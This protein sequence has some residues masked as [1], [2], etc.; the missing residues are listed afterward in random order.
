MIFKQL[1]LNNFKSHSN[2]TIDFDSGVT[3]IVG[4]NGAGKS[5]IFEAISF[6]L[7]KQFTS[8]NLADLMRSN[9]GEFIKE[10]SVSLVFSSNGIDYKIVRKLFKSKSKDNSESKPTVKSSVSLFK[11]DNQSFD[12]ISL[13]EGD[14]NV[15]NQIQ[16]ILEM[17]SDVFLNAIYVRQGEIAD[18]VGKT[19]AERKKLISKLLKLE[20]LEIAWKNSLDIINNY[21]IKSSELKGMIASESTLMVD[22]KAKKQEFISLAERK[23]KL[24]ND[25]EALNK[26]K[27]IISENKN[28]IEKEKMAF[29]EFTYK[30]DNEKQLFETIKKARSELQNQIDELSKNEEEMNRLEKYSKKLP[31]YIDFEEACKNLLILKK[32][33]E[34]QNA[35]L[36]KIKHH[37]EVLEN[38]KSAYDDYLI[39]ESKLKDL[40]EKKSKLSANLKIADKYNEDKKKVETSLKQEELKFKEFITKTKDVLTGFAD[41]LDIKEEIYLEDLED[42]FDFD[43]LNN[44]IKAIKEIID[45]D[46]KSNNNLTKEVLKEISTAQTNIESAKK[47]LEDLDE[48][49]GKCPICLSDINEDK[50]NELIYSYKNII[51]SKDSK[52][53]LFNGELS[54]IEENNKELSSKLELINDLEKEL[55]SIKSISENRNTHKKELL[56][57]TNKLKDLESALIELKEIEDSLNNVTKNI[58]ELKLSY[59][60]YNESK[61]A[62]NVLPKNQE[63]QEKLYHIEGRIKSE[64][65]RVDN[66]TKNDI[67][68]SVEMSEE[69]LE[70]KIK[71]LREKDQR[72]NQLTG[73]VRTKPKYISQLEEKKE[74]IK[75]KTLEIERLNKAIK[76]SKYDSEK[77]EKTKLLEEST[78]LRILNANKELSEVSGRIS[79][80]IPVIEKIENDLK[81]NKI[82]KEELESCE[83]F[84]KLLTDIRSLYSKDGIQKVLRN[85]SKPIIQKNTKE[86]FEKFNFE[87]SDLL[88]DENYDISLFGPEGEAKL[89]M[90]SGG[91]KIAVA[92]ALR[93]GI[94]KAMAKGNIE[95]ILLDEPTIHL[96]DGRKND[97]IG[98]IREMS[99]IPQM[100]IVTHDEAL[101][102]AADY[103]YKV[104]KENGISSVKEEILTDVF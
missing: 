23:E 66:A 6:A 22:L 45:I 10:S 87:Y 42:E 25:L 74:E 38:N 2:T 70:S 47:S 67:Y 104:K 46:I 40:T 77:Y 90:I 84:L 56:E 27:E 59:D 73:L 91:E 18:L 81:V 60:S 89:D 50:K 98:L 64:L 34:E 9:K 93:L 16:N 99:I 49:E 31:I 57:L 20:D 1:K 95:T 72:F 19:P 94:T 53:Q 83:K 3:L 78:S 68:L 17:D 39:L 62:L 92:L 51:T 12:F 15:N 36:E 13:C 100:I 21:K 58:E 43:I 102:S 63:I 14:K 65:E 71:D 33:K 24:T 48:V 35:I 85:S 52:L 7:F 79:G 61:T 76:D 80:I 101:E 37:N 86:F 30:L 28:K 8:K 26:D 54:R 44:I 4:E 97:L 96:D 55:Y 11:R 75:L 5:S 103:I 82:Y 88:L 32:D 69:E 29:D 41:K